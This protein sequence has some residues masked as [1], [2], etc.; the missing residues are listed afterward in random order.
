MLGPPLLDRQDVHVKVSRP[1]SGH[2][3][4]LIFAGR[5]CDA[6]GTPISSDGQLCNY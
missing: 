6:H 2:G 3:N 1:C 5:K 4:F